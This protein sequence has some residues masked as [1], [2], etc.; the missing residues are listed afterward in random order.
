MVEAVKTNAQRMVGKDYI[1]LA[2]FGVLLFLIFM[3]CAS[4]LGMNAA[5]FWYT[6]ALGGLIGGVVWMYV[7]ARIP[8]RGALLAMSLLI[9]VVGLLLGM[10]WTG[11]VGIAVGGVLAELIAGSGDKRTTARCIAAFVVFTLCFWAGQA[12]LIVLSGQAYV[13][14]VVASGM[15]AEYGQGLIDFIYGPLAL[16]AILATIAGSAVGGVIGA[17]LFKKHFAKIAA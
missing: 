9:A 1:T 10:L 8:K 15:S 3:V 4:V 17:Q 5:T 11:P 14:M 2:I 6:H 7:A 12:S 16:V 13:D